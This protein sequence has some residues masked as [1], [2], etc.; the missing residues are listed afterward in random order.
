MQTVKST[1]AAALFAGLAAS[2]LA[3]GA[4]AQDSN[5]STPL[6][7][8]PA[9]GNQ[10]GTVA[11]PVRGGAG[12]AVPPVLQPA[13]QASQ[14]K[15][16]PR[17]VQ[18]AKPVAK[19]APAG[20][21]VAAL[22]PVTG[23]QGG[24]V[25]DKKGAF[26]YCIAESRYANG[27][28]LLIA[29][30]GKGDFNIGI[31]MPGASLPGKGAWQVKLSVDNTLTRDRHGVATQP[32]LLMIANGQDT[33]LYDALRKGNTLTIRGPKDEVAFTLT[34]TDKAL[35]ELATCA[36]HKGD[37]VA[38]IQ[39]TQQTPLPPSLANILDQA[40]LKA[41]KLIDL[42]HFPP[43]Q[44]PADYAWVIGNARGGVQER[45]APA[46]IDFPTLTTDYVEEVHKRCGAGQF[47]SSLDAP[48]TVN[49]VDIRT[50][51]L[52]CT[53]SKGATHV[54]LLMYM[55]PSR[56]FTVFFHEAAATDKAAADQPRDAILKVVEKLASELKTGAT[57]PA[58]PPA[59]STGGTPAA[60]T[61][62]T[63]AASTDGK[64]ATTPAPAPSSGTKP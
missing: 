24:A 6:L 51:S 31:G 50:G 59:A 13:P 28:A 27:M 58:Q 21:G 42:T 47:T 37:G 64:P 1:L 46:N 63:P 5:P 38:K 10:G 25:P 56:L 20:P 43:N 22:K 39:P 8:I 4:H 18:P 14:P 60:S 2:C 44:R 61:G 15:A 23:W 19:A 11:P 52:E 26:A 62:G 48:K 9:Q 57:P 34:G 16:A 7:Q 49:H 12:V 54:A 30:D 29:R 35:S 36:E 17:F 3:G 40:G 33:Q 32:D 41:A 45:E 55:T 53:G